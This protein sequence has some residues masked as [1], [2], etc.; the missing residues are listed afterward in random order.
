MYDIRPNRLAHSWTIT[1]DT[2]ETFVDQSPLVNENDSIAVVDLYAAYQHWAA[3][4][5]CDTL[6]K[7]MFRRA[8]NECATFTKTRRYQ[9][10]KRRQYY[11][12]LAL[13]HSSDQ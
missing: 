10:G 12:D 7:V 6:T 5:E 9:E 4:N 1:V 8:L 11:N 3:K 2:I 13:K